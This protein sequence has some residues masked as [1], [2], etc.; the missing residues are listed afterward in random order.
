MGGSCL[1]F[2][3]REVGCAHSYAVELPRRCLGEACSAQHC[4]GP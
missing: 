4:E 3:Y 2:V 1:D